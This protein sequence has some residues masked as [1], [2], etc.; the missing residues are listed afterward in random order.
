MDMTDLKDY[1]AVS[2]DAL[3]LLKAAMVLCQK[4]VDATR[5]KRKSKPQPPC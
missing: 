5:L 4:A 2:K 3:D 1:V